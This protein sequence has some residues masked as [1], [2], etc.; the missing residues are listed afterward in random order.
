L[1]PDVPELLL[2]LRSLDD[3]IYQKE[4]LGPGLLVLFCSDV[5][6]KDV[7]QQGKLVEGE[8]AII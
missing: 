2:E 6:Q 8:E 4:H 5:L 3:F 7:G 1:I